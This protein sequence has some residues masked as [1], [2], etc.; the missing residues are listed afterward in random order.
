MVVG[1]MHVAYSVDYVNA[2]MKG[3]LESETGAFF[4][5]TPTMTVKCR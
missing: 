5:P 4:C 3:P 1:H 2:V